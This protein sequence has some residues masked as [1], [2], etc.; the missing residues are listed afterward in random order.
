VANI[1]REYGSSIGIAA[2]KTQGIESEKNDN[3][4]TMRNDENSGSKIRPA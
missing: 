2:D 3:S 1:D 4:A